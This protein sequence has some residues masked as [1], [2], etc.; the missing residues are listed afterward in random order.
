[1]MTKKRLRS[2][3][4]IIDHQFGDERFSLLGKKGHGFSEKP[5]LGLS[6]DMYLVKPKPFRL[7]ASLMKGSK[8]A[9]RA[10]DLVMVRNDSDRK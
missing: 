7:A 3:E 2:D 8:T 6:M 10:R 1:M 4:I 5:L 9:Y